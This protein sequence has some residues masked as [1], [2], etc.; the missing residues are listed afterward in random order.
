MIF[1]FIL[2]WSCV[3]LIF[4]YF[5]FLLRVCV[6]VCVFLVLTR[7][8][9]TGHCTLGEWQQQLRMGTLL[10]GYDQWSLECTESPP[11]ACGFC[12]HWPHHCSQGREGS[13]ARTTW[14]VHCWLSDETL[15]AVSLQQQYSLSTGIDGSLQFI[16]STRKTGFRPEMYVAQPAHSLCMCKP[17]APHKRE[18]IRQKKIW[19]LL[20]ESHFQFLVSLGPAPG[21][22]VTFRLRKIVNMLP[23]SPWWENISIL[24]LHAPSFRIYRC[25]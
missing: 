18:R 14:L 21:S 24:W 7:N 15:G 19:F 4:L 16:R 8:E 20:I 10:Q 6:C 2:R 22:L 1:S 17:L 25:K 9:I 13:A 3:I 23:L 12:S 5:S 11:S